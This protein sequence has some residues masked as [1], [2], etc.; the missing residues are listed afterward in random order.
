MLRRNFNS[1]KPSIFAYW[2]YSRYFSSIKKNVLP[3]IKQIH[4]DLF[5]KESEGIR[6]D[7]LLFLQQLNELVERIDQMQVDNL[8]NNGLTVRY[9]FAVCYDFRFHIRV[10]KSNILSKCVLSVR[11]PTELTKK[12][13]LSHKI[14]LREIR[15]FLANLGVIHTTI[16]LEN[17]WTNFYDDDTSSKHDNP[18][19]NFRKDPNCIM[20]DDMM[21]RKEIYK[22]IGE[23]MIATRGLRGRVHLEEGS[24]L[25]VRQ[26]LLIP[27]VDGYIRNGNVLVMNMSLEEELVAVSTMR[28]F[29]IESGSMLNFS[30]RRWYKVL[31]IIDGKRV[32]PTR[33][34]SKNGTIVQ[35]VFDCEIFEERYLVTVPKKFRQSL[36][37][38]YL[39]DKLPC[40]KYFYDENYKPLFADADAKDMM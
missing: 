29:L 28:E 36:F 1:F 5:A 20:V 30:F 17:P 21:V 32:M 19:L 18:N 13:Q 11:A 25:S 3:I 2:R 22:K 34:S 38:R 27:E 15:T 6:S 40:S 7:N 16:G 4:P 12:T 26:L 33:S 14:A 10:R 23:E 37:L 24:D 39:A 35:S 31:I 8:P 9:P